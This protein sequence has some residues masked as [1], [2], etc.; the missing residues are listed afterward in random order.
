VTVYQNNPFNPAY[1]G[2]PGRFIPREEREELEK[3][4]ERAREEILNSEVFKRAMI[5]GKLPREGE[6]VVFKPAV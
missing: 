1:P 6:K 2:A 3:E 4:R 5:E